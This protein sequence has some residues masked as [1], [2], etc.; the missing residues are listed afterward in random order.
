VSRYLALIVLAGI[1]A[2]SPDA[3]ED[4]ATT[5]KPLQ[6]DTHEGGLSD[7]EMAADLQRAWDDGDRS[8]RTAWRLLG[9]YWSRHDEESRRRHGELAL[10]M[11]EEHPEWGGHNPVTELHPKLHPE[12]YERGGELWLRHVEES[13]DS[14][15]VLAHASSYFTL[16]NKELA[17]E[18]LLKG[19]ERF[20]SAFW[21]RRLGHLYK[22]EDSMEASLGAYREAV[23][24]ATGDERYYALEKAAVAAFL[25]RDYEAA[26]L[27]A[28]ELLG[29]TEELG[30]EGIPTFG[31]AAHYSNLILGHLAFRCGDYDLA[32]ERLLK[33]GDTPGGPALNSYGPNMALALRLLREGRSEA[34]LAYLD[35]CKRFWKEGRLDEWQEDIRAGQTPPFENVS[36]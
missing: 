26:H 10:W 24:L 33:A 9:F 34:V 11:I 35:S 12:A 23:R 6:E 13:P 8:V 18:L 21:Y 32:E 36:Y 27:Y 25:A 30:P 29:L 19:A 3:E 15:S 22:L 31:S 4:T 2:C 7:P 20:P 1:A 17:E 5:T 28:D 16:A 14:P